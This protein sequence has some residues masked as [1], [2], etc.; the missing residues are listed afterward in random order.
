MLPLMGGLGS[1]SWVTK[2][3]Q[4]AHGAAKTPTNKHIINQLALNMHPI[5]WKSYLI[6]STSCSIFM[7]I[8]LLLVLLIF[9]VCHVFVLKKE[10]VVK[11]L[12]G[13]TKCHYN[14]EMVVLKLNT[15]T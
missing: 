7:L 12:N 6:W 1:S 11:H 15:L 5:W 4:G 10:N 2:I 3:P 8:A 14:T 9:T 13:S